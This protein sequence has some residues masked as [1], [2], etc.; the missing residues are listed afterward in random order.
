VN[1]ELNREQ[2]FQLTPGPI[3][4]LFGAK[5]RISISQAHRL[6]GASISGTEEG[7]RTDRPGENVGD[8][9]GAARALNLDA[10]QRQMLQLKTKPIPELLAGRKA[11]R[12]VV[13]PIRPL[14]APV[15][16]A[17]E[18]L[19]AAKSL[20]SEGDLRGAAEAY[21]RLTDLMPTAESYIVLGVTYFKLEE[22]ERS[23]AAMKQS[24]AAARKARRAKQP[25][26]QES[27]AAARFGLALANTLMGKHPVALREVIL[28]IRLGP[29]HP[30]AHL[31]LA[32]LR[33]QSEQWK[34]AVG[35]FEEVIRLSPELREPYLY[36]ADLYRN[37]ADEANNSQER[38]ESLQQ[39]IATYRLYLDRFPHDASQA[40]NDLG[41]LYSRM[42]YVEEGIREYTAAVESD[43]NNIRALINLATAYLVRDRLLEAEAAFTKAAGAWHREPG[44]ISPEDTTGLLE[45]HAITLLKLHG[46]GDEGEYLAQAERAFLRTIEVD[47]RSQQAHINLGVLYGGVGRF[48]AAEKEFNKVLQA[49]PENR[50]ARAGLSEVAVARYSPGAPGDPAEE[51][52]V[53]E[54]LRFLKRFRE[55]GEE[56]EQRETLD[57][58]KKALDEDRLSNRARFSD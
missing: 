53:E 57:Y 38:D 2:S 55:E 46:P 21:R 28:S 13:E 32:H 47:P 17:E 4:E 44:A 14:S 26:A 31:L 23:A 24:L 41:V 11:R 10:V 6:S 9:L 22:Y 56:D 35:A 15:S 18:T 36:L 16:S 49:D 29:T 33:A 45:G 43:P 19:R 37:L 25:V 3:L 1:L 58:L 7:R 50:F 40:H 48:E 5:S 51:Q 52:R 8:L 34:A 27:E 39:A 12:S 42:G 20:E 30:G 54:T